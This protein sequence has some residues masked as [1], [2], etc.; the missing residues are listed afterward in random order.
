MVI[1][2]ADTAL[3]V[4]F[5]DI[6]G[7]FDDHENSVYYWNWHGMVW[8]FNWRHW[9]KAFVFHGIRGAFEVAAPGFSIILYRNE[10]K[11]RAG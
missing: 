8:E 7:Q 9:P 3:E 5:E 11:D 10:T 6:E 2:A 4:T 1:Q